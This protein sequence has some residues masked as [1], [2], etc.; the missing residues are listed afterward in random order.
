MEDLNEMNIAELQPGTTL[1]NGKYTIEKK[2]GAGGFGIAYKAVQN[3]LCRDVC[4]KEYF[5]AGK[6]VRNTRLKTVLAQGVSDELFEKYRQ[7][8]VRE[9]KVLADLHHPNIVDVIDV[10]DENSTSYMV[11]V[12]IEGQSLQSIIEK[13]GRLS[14]DDAVNYMAQV[15]EA[16]GYVH[17]HHIL[18]RDIKPDNIMITSD[19]RAILIDFGSAREFQHDKT[20]AQTSMLTLGYAPIEQHTT[21]SRKGSYT[22]IYAIGA[23]LYFILTGQVPLDAAAR[24]TEKMPEPKKLNPDIPD[25]ANR[26]IMKAMQIKAENRHQ[27]VQEF[28]NDLL[29]IKP[30]KP[31]PESES[32][33]KKWLWWLLGGIGV[34]LILI[35]GIIWNV[36]EHMEK[37][38]E[39]VATFLNRYDQKLSDCDFFMSNIYVDKRGDTVNSIWFND[40]LKSLKEIEDL[41]NDD[42][43]VKTGRT[44][45]F[46]EKLS[47]YQNEL[48]RALE[49]VSRK[50][51]QLVEDD[52]GDSGYA[53]DILKRRNRIESILQQ[54]KEKRSAIEI[55]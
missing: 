34:G 14:Y 22:D 29:N 51:A 11:M 54:S 32:G 19:S 40:C 3:G 44:P 12:Y 41:E 23:T 20:Q 36:I 45:C 24:M 25:A 47:S 5:P 15:T 27:S 1:C 16:V 49:Y 46:Q 10:F 39:R 13:K 26:T 52:L 6:C 4:I 2:L 18:H 55:E 38:Q 30:S 37:D 28:M 48:S 17:A 7:A 50:Y 8:F 43:F 9:A 42:L 53:E 35:G 21:N 33:T 31:I